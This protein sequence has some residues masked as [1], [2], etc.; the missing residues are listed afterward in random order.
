MQIKS[1]H[2]KDFRQFYG[3]QKLDFAIDTKKNVTLIHAENGVGK[4]TLLNSILWTFFGKT[5]SKFEQRE[6]IVNFTAEKEGKNSAAWFSNSCPFCELPS[7]VMDYSLV[8]QKPR[9]K[10]ACGMDGIRNLNVNGAAVSWRGPLAVRRRSYTANR[11]VFRFPHIIF[12]RQNF[13]VGM[14][15][16]Q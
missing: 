14:R 4:T 7:C 10:T 2:L 11:A 15:N 6:K 12:G 5:T 13:G 1:I 16:R 8:F 9:S 3:E